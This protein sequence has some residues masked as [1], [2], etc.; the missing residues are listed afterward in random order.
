M[1]NGSLQPGGKE[2]DMKTAAIVLAGGSGSRM[3]STEKKQYMRIGGRPVLYYA[4]HAFEQCGWIDE[5]VVVCSEEDRERC[6]TEITQRYGFGKVHS[7]VAGGKERH[8]SVYEGLKALK[9]CDYVL[10]HD[11]AR[12]FVDAQ[13]LER[14]RTELSEVHACTV[15]MPVKDTIKLSNEAG[16]VEQTLPRERLWIIQT[17]QAF[18]YPLI[19]RAHEARR[20][21]ALQGVKITDDAMLVEQAER[22]PVKLIEG[23]YEN[24]KIT[25]PDDL[26]LAEA[27]LKKV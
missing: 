11:G 24:I 13:M 1:R 16:F 15:G 5:V 4:L 25:T 20:S 14:I 9:D 18:A 3:H 23:S 2:A 6:R 7:I 26:L 21:G 17:P 19:L 8:D 27:F 22:V 12:P 10:I